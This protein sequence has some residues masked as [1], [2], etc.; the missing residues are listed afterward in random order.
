MPIFGI[1]NG[2]WAESTIMIDLKTRP[3][4]E[5]WTQSARKE[6]ASAQKNSR[7]F[8]KSLLFRTIVVQTLCLYRIPIYLESVL[9]M[10]EK[11]RQ[12]DRWESWHMKHVAYTG[13]HHCLAEF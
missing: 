9:K 1:K 11:R 13:L 6:Q 10:W 5:A 3:E 4:T 7:E 2:F 12:E 8:R